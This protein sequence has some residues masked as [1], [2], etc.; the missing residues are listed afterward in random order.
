MSDHEIVDEDMRRICADPLPWEALEGAHIAVTGAYGMLAAYLVRALLAANQTH[1]LGLRVTG[2]VRSVATARA[3]LGDHPALA[4]LESDLSDP[5]GLEPGV[6]HVVHAASL[7]S[8]RFYDV[9]PVGTLAPNLLG[10]WHLLEFAR[11]QQVRRFLYVSS[12][13]V[14]GVVPPELIP[15]AEDSFGVVDPAQ[16]RACY[17]EGKRA[18]ETMCVAFW[19]QHSVQA[20][21]ARPFHTYG[22]GLALDDGRVFAD[23]VANI[24]RGEDIV[25]KS[26]GNAVRAFCYISDAIRGLIRILVQGRAGAAYNVGNEDAMMSVGALADRLVALFPDRGLR[27][28]RGSHRGGYLESPIPANA[29]DTSRLRSLGWQPEVGIDEGFARTI[30]SFS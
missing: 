17:S 21:I 18:A 9:D 16:V 24:V 23:F 15:I 2:V 4:F 10:T 12:G 20:V 5:P 25:L 13:E 22:P 14:Y 1:D 28:V 29:P 27:V 8:P 26:A 7:A 19:H 11:R 30:R 3:R 6:T